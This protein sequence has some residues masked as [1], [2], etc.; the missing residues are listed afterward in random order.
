M[1]THYWRFCAAALLAVRLLPAQAPKPEPDV[2]ELTDGE[3]LLGH[4]EQSSGASIKFKSDV[5]GELTIDWSKVK[6]LSTSDKFAIVPKGVELKRNSDL[7]TIPE[8]AVAVADQKITVTPAA[9]AAQTVNV[10]D[11]DH[12]IEQTQ[13][14]NAVHRNPSFFSDWGGGVTV[15]ASLVQATQESRTFTTG[16]NL[17][18][19]VPDEDWLRRRN[20]TLLDLSVTYGTLEQPHTPLVKTEIYHG[21]IER[22][23]Y[24][25]NSVY[26]F[27]QASFDHNFSQGLDLQ[28]TYALGLGWSVIKRPNESLD[29]K[30]GITYVRQEFQGSSATRS[31]VGSVFEEDYQRGLRHGIVFSEQVIVSPGWS[32]TSALTAVGKSTLTVPA[33]KRTNFTLGIIDNYL[34]GPPPGFK[35]NSFQMILGLNYA[36]R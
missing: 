17:V 32:D 35:K 7:S 9:G 12:L 19:T 10:A 21:D 27:A 1:L 26:G 18:R 23:E 30:A 29:L 11:A 28:Q 22:D 4:F 20:R 16:I 5:L 31:V 14:E 36:L 25:S 2:L 13:F 3:R 34:Y 6:T 15:G 24:F 8:G 33:Y